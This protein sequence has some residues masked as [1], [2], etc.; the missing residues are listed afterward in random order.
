MVDN[1][2]NSYQKKGQVLLQYQLMCYLR[3]GQWMLKQKGKSLHHA[4]FPKV[5]YKPTSLKIKIII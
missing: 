2:K 3:H 5:S 4:I 1:N